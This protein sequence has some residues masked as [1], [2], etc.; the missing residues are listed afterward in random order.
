MSS[1]PQIARLE[2][3]PRALLASDGCSGP[4]PGRLAMILARAGTGKTAFLTTIALDAIFAG[5][6]VLHI[7]I[8]STVDKVR[9]WYDDILSELHRRGD[10]SGN[11]LELQLAVE[12]SRHIHTYAHH[13][14]SVAKVNETLGLMN[15]IMHFG[16]RVIIVDG[17]DLEH[18]DPQ[19]VADLRD[20]AQGAEAE[21]WISCRVRRDGPP[22]RPGHLPPPADHFEALCDW[23]FILEP[24]GA[25]IRLHVLKDHDQILDRNTHILLDPNTQLLISDNEAGRS[26]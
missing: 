8:D 6:K 9:T 11:S 24:E 2:R 3:S 10:T 18:I 20:L 22:T 17:L 16:P 25:K 7:D 26:A 23:A 19:M 12:R 1:E 13:V 5:Q 4:G 21:L 15:A 14:F